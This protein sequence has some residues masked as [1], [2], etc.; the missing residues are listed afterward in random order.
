MTCIYIRNQLYVVQVY[1]KL[2]LFK[3]LQMLLAI[4]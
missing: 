3:L 4:C 1:L 2:G